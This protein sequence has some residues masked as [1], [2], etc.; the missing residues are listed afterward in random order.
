MDNSILQKMIR[1][2]CR[3]FLND[4]NIEHKTKLTPSEFRGL[5]CLRSNNG[6]SALEFSDKIGLSPSRSSRVIE[7]MMNEGLIESIKSK[8]DRRKVELYVTEK[9]NSVDSE[10]I[11]ISNE[12]ISKIKDK[13]GAEGV[14]KVYE[15]LDIL[16]DI[17]N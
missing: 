7:K 10:I 9:G 14:D 3:C 5:Q 16:L 2:K 11:F 17:I 8:K 13:Y 15:S 4:Y 12:L 1:L 6:I